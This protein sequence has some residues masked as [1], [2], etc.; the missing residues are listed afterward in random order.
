MVVA[1]M[2]SHKRIFQHNTKNEKLLKHRSLE[3]EGEFEVIS[4]ITGEESSYLFKVK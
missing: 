4:L 3:Q 1:E 2:S